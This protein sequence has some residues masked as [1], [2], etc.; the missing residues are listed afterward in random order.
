MG[1]PTVALENGE[2][3]AY[4]HRPGTGDKTIVLIHGNMTSSLHWDTVMEALDEKYTIYAVDLRGFGE[5]SYSREI[6]RIEDFSHDVEE[7][8]AKLDLRNITLVG[9]STGGAVAMDMCI[10][11][12]EH[13]IEKCILVASAS[14]R[15]YPFFLQAQQRIAETK[16]EIIH[17]PFVTVPVETMQRMKNYAGIQ[18]VW[19]N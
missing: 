11:D 12:T 14:T 7:W 15:G 2:I 19:S 16:E 6:E 17:D 3:I 10:D 5:S 18:A 1:L 13:R 9:W 4:R 8:M